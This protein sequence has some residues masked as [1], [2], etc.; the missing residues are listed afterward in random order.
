M[1]T[2]LFIPCRFRKLGFSFC[3]PACRTSLANGLAIIFTSTGSSSVSRQRWRPFNPNV[4]TLPH[5]LTNCSNIG[6]VNSPCT[7]HTNYCSTFQCTIWYQNCQQLFLMNSSSLFLVGSLLPLSH[8]TTS[9]HWCRQ[10][11]V[12]AL[13]LPTTGPYPL[14]VFFVK[15]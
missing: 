12:N 14:L 10:I 6:R 15:P 3:K 11:H 13:T 5:C 8:G 4:K 9:K 2:Y 1:K 7:C